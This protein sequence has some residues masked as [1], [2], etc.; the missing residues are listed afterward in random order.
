MI[1]PSYRK[2]A[3]RIHFASHSASGNKKGC[4]NQVRKCSISL[5]PEVGLEPTRDM[6]PRDFKS[7]DRIGRFPIIFNPL[8]IK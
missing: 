4:S 3:K 5:M 8:D 2:Q 1:P 6:V 7:K